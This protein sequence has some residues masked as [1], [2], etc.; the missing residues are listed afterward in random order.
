MKGGPGEGYGYKTITNVMTIN[1]IYFSDY[2][3]VASDA[4]ICMSPELII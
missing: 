4:V 3:D 1:V 2:L